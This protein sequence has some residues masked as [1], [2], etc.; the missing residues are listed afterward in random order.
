M[1]DALD[2]LFGMMGMI[3]IADQMAD[4]HTLAYT[5][6]FVTTI[7][8][9]VLLPCFLLSVVALGPEHVSVIGGRGAPRRQVAKPA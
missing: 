4:T 9:F 7:W 2:C 5:A 6:L 3:V 1:N 8:F